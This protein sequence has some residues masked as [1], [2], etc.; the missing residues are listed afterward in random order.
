MGRISRGPLEPVLDPF[1]RHVLQFA[2]AFPKGL[3]HFDVHERL[4]ATYA[5]SLPIVDIKM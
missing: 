4:W 5:T 3:G 2:V 1:L